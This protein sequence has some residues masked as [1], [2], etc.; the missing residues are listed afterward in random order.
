MF[1][2]ETSKSSF[3]DR[4]S[5]PEFYPLDFR[6]KFTGCLEYISG[7]FGKHTSPFL[8]NVAHHIIHVA[9]RNRLSIL[10]KKL[11]VAGNVCLCSA[12]D[13]AV[14]TDLYNPREFSSFTRTKV[15]K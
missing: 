9:S 8:L 7:M 5:L 13:R 6:D 10:L 11:K 4:F 14:Q 1:I 2:A 3:S 15:Q 12:C